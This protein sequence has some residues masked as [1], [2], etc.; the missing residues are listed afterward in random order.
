MHKTSRPAFHIPYNNPKYKIMPN[1]YH[2]HIQPAIVHNLEASEC[3]SD[4]EPNVNPTCY[5][6]YLESILECK[7][8][9]D[10]ASKTEFPDCQFPFWYAGKSYNSCTTDFSSQEWC[11]TAIDMDSEAKEFYWEYCPTNNVSVRNNDTGIISEYVV[12]LS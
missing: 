1:S 10:N 11:A 9:W 5:E 12:I 6:A 3:R 2:Y 4:V 7:L 8:S